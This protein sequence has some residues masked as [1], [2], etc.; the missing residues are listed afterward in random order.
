MTIYRK[1]RRK[2]FR[3]ARV[4]IHA[5]SSFVPTEEREEDTEVVLYRS[6]H[7]SDIEALC[8]DWGN[9]SEDWEC[10]GDDLRSGINNYVDSLDPEERV[11]TEELLP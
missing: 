4:F 10:V 6:G 5:A 11:K 7:K 3:W 8:K 2:A 1:P 9:V